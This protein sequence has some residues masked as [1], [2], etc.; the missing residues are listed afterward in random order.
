MDAAVAEMRR[1]NVPRVGDAALVRGADSLGS[2]A[3][4]E[5]FASP[6]DPSRV[7]K[8]RRKM[9]VEDPVWCVVQEGHGLLRT[10]TSREEASA[11]MIAFLRDAAESV[12]RGVSM[13]V[14][15]LYVEPGATGR[16]L[17]SGFLAEAF[18]GRELTRR[19]VQPGIAT[20]FVQT[21][22]AWR[23]T[24]VGFFELQRC[25]LDLH[26]IGLHLS[27]EDWQ[28][29]IAIVLANLAAAQ[30]VLQF[31]HHDLHMPNVMFAS[32]N[33]AGSRLPLKHWPEGLRAE[34]AD[35]SAAAY[36][37]ETVRLVLG[38]DL[39]LE[40]ALPMG[41]LEPV[42]IDMGMA[43]VTLP[44]TTQRI[45][46]IDMPHFGELATEGMYSAVF[47]GQEGYDAQVLLND[48][49]SSFGDFMGSAT[50]RWLRQLVALV[51][52]RGAVSLPKG[53]PRA[54]AVSDLTPLE[55]LRSPLF[56]HLRVSE[57]GGCS[58]R[59]LVDLT[60]IE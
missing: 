40:V 43:S 47:E 41:T 57:L 48:I 1:M 26:R 22:D 20:G 8:V 31:K 39:V 42:I 10:F 27:G 30:A 3:F 54:G 53:R 34:P 56:A 51:H 46:R 37:S 29:T 23:T 24:Q 60:R 5:V 19:L 4:G 55:L 14:I 38:A 21:Y 25:F 59:V 13:G 18:I 9:H 7:F 33:L 32:R 15:D 11:W 6:T 35:A 58:S 2:G 44:G 49:L 17:V 45:Q 36:E 50:Q 28:A 16:V 52:S 12:I